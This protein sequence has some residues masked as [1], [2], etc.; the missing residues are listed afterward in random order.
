MNSTRT[1]RAFTMIELVVGLAVIAIIVATVIPAAM[2]AREAERRTRC[3]DNLRKI[4]RALSL[5]GMDNG[6]ELPRVIYNPAIGETYNA[7]TG[8]HA[9][10]PFVPGSAVAPND[11][12]ASL[13]LLVRGNYISSEFSP[14]SAV[15]ICPST[16]DV[17]DPITN[18]AGTPVG[19]VTRSNFR[20]A[21]NLSYSYSSPFSNASGYALQLDFIGRGFVL[22]ADKNPG[23]GENA[24]DAAGVPA[25]APPMKI[26]MANSLNHRRAGQNVLF[27]DMHVE[28]S[29]T[30]YCGIE[31][32]NIYT[33]AAAP[34]T[35]VS[36]PATQGFLGR[37][38][39]PAGPTDSYLVP[40]A[41]D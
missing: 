13:W 21:N 31:G 33:A 35:Q 24:G 8:P 7:F 23:R 9:D 20:S 26:A 19:A 27:G 40:T 25:D 15:F 1:R 28:F 36:S 17:A 5:Y 2:S 18:A 41:T 39:Y 3:M 12:T 11:V 10:N 14:P 6:Y 16:A 4:G 34:T 30:P 29:T 22:L 37:S 38:V 32:D